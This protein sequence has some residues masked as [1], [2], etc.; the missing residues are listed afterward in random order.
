M[1]SWKLVTVEDK[2][3]WFI[4]YW[5]NKNDTKFYIDFC[6]LLWKWTSWL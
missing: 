1:E 2:K 3:R 5:W 4:I 6:W